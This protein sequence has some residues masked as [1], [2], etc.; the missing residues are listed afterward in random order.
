MEFD[1]YKYMFLKYIYEKLK[2]KE[3]EK[4]LIYEN[5]NSLNVM[6]DDKYDIISKYFF[7]L[8]RIDIKNLS[9]EQLEK[10]HKYF[11]KDIRKFNEEETKEVIQFINETY[12][13]ML[14]P[15]TTS[16]CV[17]YGP[18]DDNYICPRD[19]IALGLYYDAFGDYDDFELENKLAPI[20]N[21]IQFELAKNI[22]CKVAVIP[23]NQMTLDNNFGEFHK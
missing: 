18:I 16:K 4:Q 11:S 19:A 3:I 2:L 12:P 15:D 9:N 20:I 8:N 7:L 1:N 13:L 22:N 23:F 10:F 14:F 17:Y 5:I 6:A 21:Y